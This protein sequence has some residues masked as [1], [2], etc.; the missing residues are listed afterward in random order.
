MGLLIGKKAIITGARRGIGRAT[1]E[2]FAANGSNVWACARSQN[3]AFE[4]DMKG[5]AEKYGVEIW[6]VYFDVTDE[7]QIKLAVQAIRK[8]K[9]RID[10]LVNMAGIV[11]DSS[12][13]QMTSIDKMKHLFDTNFFA[14]TL[15]TQ[16]ISRLMARQN[17]GSIVNIASIAG[18][19][20]EPA[21]YEYATSKAAIV[22]ATKHLARELAANNIR[23]N[24][25]APGMIETE[26][27]AKI[28]ENLK[29]HMLNKV[30][31]GRMGKPSEIANVVAFLASDYA[32]YMTGQIIRVD[33]GI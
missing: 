32:S 17:S 3:E 21:Q 12:T 19:D 7:A 13:F 22:G 10:A 29:N 23:V 1:V 14:V 2:A 16:Y 30:I 8:Q 5:L 20:G 6:P 26:M 9:V 27:G 31:M 33:G 11:E 28:E 4:A 15:L 18:L 24:A 25:V